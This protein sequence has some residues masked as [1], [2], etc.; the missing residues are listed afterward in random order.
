[1][2]RTQFG[3]SILTSTSTRLKN[4]PGEWEQNDTTL[5]TPRTHPFGPDPSFLSNVP[6]SIESTCSV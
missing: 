6:V 3:E 5:L 4:K 1:M 2:Q